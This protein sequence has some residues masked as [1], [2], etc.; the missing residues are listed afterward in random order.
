MKNYLFSDSTPIDDI[1]FI[2]GIVV[3]VH[4]K[5]F[6]TYLNKEVNKE[7]NLEGSSTF[8]STYYI[9]YQ[10]FK[11]ED[12]YT[13]RVYN[14]NFKFIISDFVKGLKANEEIINDLKDSII[15]IQKE[16]I[17]SIFKTNFTN[18]ITETIDNI[19]NISSLDNIEITDF[20]NTED[21]YKVVESLISD[22]RITDFE[23]PEP[24]IWVDKVLI[25][26]DKTA[27]NNES[28]TIISNCK[29]KITT[30]V[31]WITY[32]NYSML[33]GP[34][35]IY[36]NILE[37]TGSSRE[38]HIF[39]TSENNEVITVL[40]KQEEAQQDISISSTDPISFESDG[41]VTGSEDTS[42]T[43]TIT[44]NTDNK[45]LQWNIEKESSG[46]NDWLTISPS[47]G[48]G[49][50]TITI[51]ASEN[52][53][54]F[55]RS[56]IIRINSDKGNFAINVYQKEKVIEGAGTRRGATTEEEI[57]P[58]SLGNDATPTEILLYNIY[59]QLGL[60]KTIKIQNTDN[61]KF[62]VETSNS[63]SDSNSDSN[64]EN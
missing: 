2:E 15:D 16:I 35:T 3:K 41:K 33:Y 34:K 22:K 24:F 10:N 54:T 42:I 31:N 6:D 47:L 28:L 59:K 39:I 52:T 21:T 23:H 17:E 53:N 37:N 55:S 13:Y 32:T 14:R 5:G 29:W 51:T 62:K 48:R 20:G 44:C 12:I 45:N 46:S 4:F 36:F 38:G 27:H 57:I 25:N 49:T 64:S 61:D 18:V 60:N 63:N 8:N 1:N 26:Y 43:R 30:D 9:V 40:L 19:Y 58:I 50:K 11:K 56:C 7:Q